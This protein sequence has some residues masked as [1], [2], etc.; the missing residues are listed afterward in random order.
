MFDGH[1]VDRGGVLGDGCPVGCRYLTVVLDRNVLFGD[2]G[3]CGRDTEIVD[4]PLP[5]RV[6][7]D[8][9][10]EV[11]F[12]PV[13][14]VAPH[15]PTGGA[16]GYGAEDVEVELGGMVGESL[17]AVGTG[18]VE[19]GVELSTCSVTRTPGSGISLASS[20]YSALPARSSTTNS[21]AQPAIRA[22]TNGLQST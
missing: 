16:C 10:V 22:P 12:E 19:G 6:I 4:E 20:T 17:H 21:S 13:C 8:G 11:A 14:L 18:V 3:E 7:A 9:L 2:A 5:H 15:G 1:G